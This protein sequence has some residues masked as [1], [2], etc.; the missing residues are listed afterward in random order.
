MRERASL[1]G[2]TMDISC[3]QTTFTVNAF[4]PVPQV[5]AQPRTHHDKGAA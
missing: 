5:N 1:V 3:D 4:V 2:G